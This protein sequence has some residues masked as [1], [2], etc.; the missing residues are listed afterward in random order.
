MKCLK[1]PFQAGP[2][3][4]TLSCKIRIKQQRCRLQK[5]CLDVFQCHKRSNEMKREEKTPKQPQ[6]GSAGARGRAGGRAT[7]DSGQEQHQRPFPKGLAQ[8]RAG[9]SLRGHDGGSI[10]VSSGF[11]RRSCRRGEM[12]EK[13]K[14][15]SSWLDSA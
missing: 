12:G 9:G 11:A 14:V 5:G 3:P 13:P 15:W 10:C 1:S 4:T 2:E 6:K 8:G 7:M